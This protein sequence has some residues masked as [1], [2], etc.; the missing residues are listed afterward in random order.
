MHVKRRNC[1][2]CAQSERFVAIEPPDR[3]LEDILEGSRS[4]IVYDQNKAKQCF[5]QGCE[6]KAVDMCVH[7][8]QMYC[9]HEFLKQHEV[10]LSECRTCKKGM[11]SWFAAIVI[12][13]RKL[14]ES[15]DKRD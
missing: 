11:F 7:C 2:K 4:S 1:P 6:R 8:M 15:D 13:I 12:E 3:E 9:Q 10:N 14:G 5:R